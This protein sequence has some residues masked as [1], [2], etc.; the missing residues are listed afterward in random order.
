MELI[1]AVA[2][3]APRTVVVLSNG[4]VLSL[5][6]WHDD[7]DAI[8]EGWLLGQAGVRLL[9]HRAGRLDG[10][11][12][13]GEYTVQIGENASRV[14]AEQ[15]VTLPGDPV[16]KVLSL[17]STVEDWFS[18]P[19]VG[20]AIMGAIAESMTGE[21]AAQLEQNADMLQMIASMPMRR[22]LNFTGLQTTPEALDEMIE[23][24]RS[25]PSAT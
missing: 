13:A 6:D 11:L 10:V 12:A 8:L 24:S 21:R 3:A 20:P 4:G 19:A 14:V 7:V 22:F 5:E 1:R 9:R 15:T 25:T 23:L 17:D 2:A 18:H 16:T